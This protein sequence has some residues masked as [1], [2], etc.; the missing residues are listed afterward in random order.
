MRDVAPAMFLLDACPVRRHGVVGRR[1]ADGRRGGTTACPPGNGAPS[2]GTD[3]TFAQQC[4]RISQ[5]E[6]QEKGR[7][8]QARSGNAGTS[9]GTPG[10]LL[11][12]ARTLCRLARSAQEKDAAAYQAIATA[13]DAATRLQLIKDRRDQE[14]MESQP[15]PYR[16][17][18]LA[19]ADR[20]KYIANLPRRI[21]RNISTG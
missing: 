16:E 18:K 2:S 3:G 8:R 7:R 15:K 19:P 6:P 4:Q 1:P 10:S 21:T 13:F 12:N 5:S 20:A 17:A 14:W 11:E 9:A